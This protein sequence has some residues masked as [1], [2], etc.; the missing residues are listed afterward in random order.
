MKIYFSTKTTS[1]TSQKILLSPQKARENNVPEGSF[2]I[3]DPALISIALVD[4]EGGCFYAELTDTY[5]RDDCDKECQDNTLPALTKISDPTANGIRMS[6]SELGHK[7][8]EW[9]K[10]RHEATLWCVSEL[11]LKAFVSIFKLGIPHLMKAKR[12]GVV[13][14]MQL[15][16]LEKNF[17]IYKTHDLTKNN[18]LGE[19][20]ATMILMEHKW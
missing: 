18:A 15:S 17:D 7:L 4:D 5:I 19:A 11:D 1:Q 6:H 20:T 13:S 2:Q 10:P 3:V 16:L 9:L 8:M 14:R 12:L